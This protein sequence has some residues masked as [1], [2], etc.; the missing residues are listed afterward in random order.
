VIDGDW[1]GKKRAYLDVS[2]QATTVERR[3]HICIRYVGCSSR[4]IN[5]STENKGGRPFIAN[6]PTSLGHGSTSPEF[7]VLPNGPVNPL[8][9]LVSTHSVYSSPRKNSFLVN[10]VIPK[11]ILTGRVV[12]SRET[13]TLSSNKIC[14]MRCDKGFKYKAVYRER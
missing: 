2:A 1:N 10:N 5:V 14:E 3:R 11:P 4:N 6:G 9:R 13:F 8:S 7:A 12:V